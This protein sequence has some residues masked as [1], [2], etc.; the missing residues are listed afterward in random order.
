MLS[1]VL[2]VCLCLFIRP[3]HWIQINIS[4]APFALS[5]SS[6]R[7]FSAFYNKKVAATREFFTQRLTRAL[8]HR[9]SFFR[10]S[11]QGWRA[12]L[13]RWV[14]LHTYSQMGP[15]SH[16]FICLP[17]SPPFTLNSH[18]CSNKENK[19]HS[20]HWRKSGFISISENTDCDLLSF[21]LLLTQ[22]TEDHLFYTQ[23]CKL[24]NYRCMEGQIC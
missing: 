18:F 21:I 3:L 6:Y 1:I 13:N 10:Q 23:I 11:P 20:S 4:S 15:F 8:N 2:L 17:V 9:L 22:C 16:S 19:Q 24:S 5:C 7:F 12:L 14:G